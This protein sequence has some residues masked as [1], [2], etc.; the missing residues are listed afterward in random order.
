MFN[1]TS[2]DAVDPGEAC[3]VFSSLCQACF[4]YILLNDIINHFTINHQD[5]FRDFSQRPRYIVR[6][7]LTTMKS[8]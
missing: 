2:A 7:K 5:F 6:L 4:V 8:L 1:N 3:K